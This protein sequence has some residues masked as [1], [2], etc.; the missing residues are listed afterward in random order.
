MKLEKFQNTIK[1]SHKEAYTNV[2]KAATGKFHM[3]AKSTKKKLKKIKR[4]QERFQEIS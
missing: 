3:Y 4:L 2:F 1:K